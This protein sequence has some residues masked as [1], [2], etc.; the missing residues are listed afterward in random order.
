[1]ISRVVAVGGPP[2]SGKSTAGR[3][4]AAALGLTYRSAG[5]VFRAE[6]RRFGLDLEAFGHYAEIHPE[7]DRTLDA[8]MQELATPGTLLDGRV[9]GEL[10]RRR[11]VPVYE[12]LVTADESERVRRVAARDGQSVEEAA[13]RLRDREASERT[14]YYDLYGLRLDEVRADVTVD[15]TRVPAAEV[16]RTIVEFLTAREAGRRP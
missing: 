4:V 11:S 5:D 10:C 14:R 6:A 2:G 3:G 8:R 16:V 13:R 9:Q 15:S 1:M 12:I 7:V